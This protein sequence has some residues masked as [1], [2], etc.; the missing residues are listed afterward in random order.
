MIRLMIRRR[1]ARA[2]LAA[3]A[4]AALTGALAVTPTSVAGAPR[5]VVATH[6]CP[7]PHG[8]EHLGPTYLNSLSVSATN[9]N[10]GLG[11]VKA[12][13][14]CQVHHGGVKARCSSSV[15]GFRCT[16]KRGPSIPTEFFSTVSCTRGGK[17]VDYKY[18]QFT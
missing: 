7:I 11:V 15:E 3:L 5:A 9:C 1:P 14:S 6:S 16:E 17:K 2:G 18:S 12:Y 10:T 4:C 13:H 8:G